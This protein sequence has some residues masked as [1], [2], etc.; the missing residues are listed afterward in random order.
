MSSTFTAPIRVNT[1][2]TTSNDGTL[3]ADN[4]GATQLTQQ[5]T[6]TGVAAA[7]AI[8]TTKI[9]DSTSSS[10]VIP[11]GSI[12]AKTGY[13]GSVYALAGLVTTPEGNQIAFAIFARSAPSEGFTVGTG[14]KQ[15]IDD[16]VEKLY[17]CGAT[18]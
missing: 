8:S 10:F 1:R 2:Q 7:G 11:A 15:A 4:T 17:L 16:V 6:F 5:A 14:T 12:R 18:L 13:I 3:S 9:G